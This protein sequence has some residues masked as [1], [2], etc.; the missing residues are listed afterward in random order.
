MITENKDFDQETSNSE[1]GTIK[2]GNVTKVLTVVGIAFGVLTFI[3]AG[4]LVYLI[5]T[6]PAPETVGIT[7]DKTTPLDESMIPT[8]LDVTLT[9][10][11]VQENTE[12]QTASIVALTSQVPSGYFV[13][14]EIVNKSQT[15]V[16][17]GVVHENQIV[18]KLLIEEGNNSF[19]LRMRTS[20]GFQFSTWSERATFDITGEHVPNSTTSS[21]GGINTEAEPNP[22][23][24][25]TNWA[26]GE[27]DVSDFADALSVAWG[28]SHI[29]PDEISEILT[30][31]NYATC[32]GINFEY[33][34]LP[35]E[36]AKPIPS[37]LPVGSYLKFNTGYYDQ[38]TGS[39]YVEFFW[40]SRP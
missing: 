33:N 31:P 30:N 21:P 27:G 29:T 35:G 5:T 6:A 22:E 7:G 23:Y 11:P 19:S 10:T 12:Y 32:M 8:I 38:S 26:K 39:V 3:F 36:M 25:N 4:F 28:G 18:T 13:N 17:K 2:Q 37:T 34:L 24:Y 14:Y 40:C 16:G 15:I 9:P 20:N 1:A